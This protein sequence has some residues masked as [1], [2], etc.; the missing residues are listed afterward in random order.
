MSAPGALGSATP[1]ASAAAAVEGTPCPQEPS[2]RCASDGRGLLGCRDGRLVLLHH[3]RGPEG[4]Q[5]RAGVVVCDMSVA[6]LDEP[7]TLEMSG[8]L[9]CSANGSQVLMCK[10]QRF[11]IEEVCGA[12]RRCSATPEGTSCAELR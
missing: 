5:L 2:P 10:G 11:A 3:C 4:C 1:G 8:N 9:A 12:G 7:C 6:R